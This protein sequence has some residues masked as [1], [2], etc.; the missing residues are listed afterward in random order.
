MLLLCV[1]RGKSTSVNDFDLV[2]KYNLLKKLIQV[3][4]FTYLITRW[5]DKYFS[6][7]GYVISIL[8]QF[9]ENSNHFLFWLKYEYISCLKFIS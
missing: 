8:S 6:G 1:E 7:L 2:F 5:I 3:S 4:V 9:L